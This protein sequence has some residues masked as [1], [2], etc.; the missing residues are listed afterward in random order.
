MKRLF[1][2]ALVCAVLVGCGGAVVATPTP[3]PIPETTPEP[4][5]EVTPEPIG[6][7]G[8]VA[9][10][11][12]Y[13][14][15]TLAITG[16]KSSFKRTVATIAY[17]A[18]LIEPVGATTVTIIIASHSATGVEKTI[19]K[20]DVDVSSPD[21]DTFANKLDLAGLV[22]NVA[23]TYVMRYLR[24]ATLLAEGQFILTK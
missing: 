18:S 15:D 23:G 8:I 7:T 24:G 20:T 22:N 12:G 1:A 16:P 10:G 13:D 9:F 2:V 4:T 17:S 21:S 6:G 3:T 11:T 14:P 19:V 5:P